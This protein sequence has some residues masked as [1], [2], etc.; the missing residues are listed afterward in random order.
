MNGMVGMLLR[1]RK[2][3][4]A[5]MADIQSMFCQF[6]MDEGSHDL[7]RF[8]WWEDGDVTK[9]ILEYRMKVHLFGAASLPGCA[10]FVL[11]RA[12]DDR[13]VQFGIDAADFV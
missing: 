4:I 8:L 12:A 10:N 1:F 5:F 7:L 13:K 3:D 9:P 11:K 6:Y 2:E